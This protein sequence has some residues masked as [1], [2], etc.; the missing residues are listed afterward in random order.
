MK[1]FR[2]ELQNPAFDED[3]SMAIL[4]DSAKIALKLAKQNWR[5][6][7]DEN[8]STVIKSGKE[9]RFKSPK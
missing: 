9:I 1:L 7:L 5:F 3:E 4:A 6:R 8:Y 2:I